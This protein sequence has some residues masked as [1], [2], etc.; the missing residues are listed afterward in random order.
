VPFEDQVRKRLQ[1]ARPDLIGLWCQFSTLENGM[2]L[3]PHEAELRQPYDE[4]TELDGWHEK[5][6]A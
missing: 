3:F 5:A 4:A 2:R 1:D 6:T